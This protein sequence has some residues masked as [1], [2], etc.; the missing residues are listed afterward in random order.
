MNA[1]TRTTPC[2]RLPPHTS[3][4]SQD[5]YRDG[6]AGGGAHT[7]PDGVPA[8]QPVGNGAGTTDGQNT[9]Y[10]PLAELN[11][12]REQFH[13][14]IDERFDALLLRLILGD[15][16]EAF[17]AG[18]GRLCPLA[19]PLSTFKG[20]RPLAV[21]LHGTEITTPTWKKAVSAILEDCD[22]D[23]H[24]HEQLLAL[25][26]RV[27]GNFRPLLSGRPDGMAAPLKISEGLYW[28]SKFDTEALLYNLTEKLLNVIGYDC[29]RVVIRYH[30][31]QQEPAEED[32]PEYGAQM[33]Q[34]LSL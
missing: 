8:Q 21:I 15:R 2:L 3:G 11:A 7:V 30:P 5:T 25:R 14:V 22:A 17:Q 9:A 28:E 33:P 13:Q 20:K 12:Y 32:V 16:T 31:P 1:K 10:L 29:Q 19:S 26:G 6:W 24:L 4:N 23:P 27:N 18:G 34:V